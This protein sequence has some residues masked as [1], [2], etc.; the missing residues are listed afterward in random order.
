[1]QVFLCSFWKLTKMR[2]KAKTHKEK[3][4]GEKMTGDNRGYQQTN[5]VNKIL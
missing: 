4:S 3:D 2:A 5:A 1:M